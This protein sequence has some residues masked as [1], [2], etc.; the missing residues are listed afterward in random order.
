M[1]QA[2]GSLIFRGGAGSHADGGGRRRE[3]Q[4]SNKRQRT[5]NQEE[6]VFHPDG[7][8][9]NCGGDH[10]LNFCRTK[11]Q[12]WLRIA[13]RAGVGSGA[14]NGNGRG[15]GNGNGRGR[16]RGYGGRAD[17]RAGR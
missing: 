16:G 10:E 13:T 4:E 1:N 15:S 12:K 7:T 8:C 5:Q 9:P 17:P 3:E 14:G 6:C 2:D 11:W